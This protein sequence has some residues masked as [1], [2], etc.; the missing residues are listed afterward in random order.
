MPI[1]RLQPGADGSVTPMVDQPSE[2]GNGQDLFT[3]FVNSALSS[4]PETFG[5]SAGQQAQSFRRD[6]PWLGV[7]SEMAGTLVPYTGWFKAAKGIGYAAKAE[8]AADALTGGI[9][10]A[11]VIARAARAVATDAPFEVGR[12]LLSTQTGDNTG[13]VATSAATNLAL[14]GVLG[15]AIGAVKGVGRDIPSMPEVDKSVNLNDPLP[16]Q[17]RTL[18]ASKDAG[19]VTSPDAADFWINKYSDIVRR[20]EPYSIQDGAR[21]DAPYVNTLE[22]GGDSSRINR[23]FRT[24]GTQL[25][26]Q[27][28][29][30]EDFQSDGA[31]TDA[32]S[33][34]GLMGK[35]DYL[36]FP[37]IVTATGK[38]IGNAESSVTSALTQIAPDTWMRREANDGLYVMAKRVEQNTQLPNAAGGK[39]ALQ[40][41]WVLFKTDSPG[42]FAPLGDAWTKALGTAASW[43]PDT[44]VPIGTPINDALQ[45]ML[46]QFPLQN[47]NDTIAGGKLPTYVG[48]ARKALGVDSLSGSAKQAADSVYRFTK[49]HVAPAMFQ[50]SDSPRAAYIFNV[51][52][53]L[54]HYADAQTSKIMNGEVNP[55]D[56]LFH[57]VLNGPATTGKVTGAA[58]N[59]LDAINPL[60]DKLSEK[61]LGEVWLAR[62]QMWDPARVQSSII[63]GEISPQSG[64]AI[65]TLNALDAEHFGNV[66]KTQTGFDIP[67]SKPQIGH[68][69]I[70][71]TWRGS[72][73]APVTDA[74]GNLVIL[75]SG[76]NRAEA[77]AQADQLVKGGKAH[78]FNWTT[79]DTF[80]A[81]PTTELQQLLAGARQGKVDLGSRQ[82]QVANALR[83][84]DARMKMKPASMRELTG[85]K[86]YVGETQPWTKQELKDI[87]HA[88]VQGYQRYQARLNVENSMQGDLLK[89][90]NENPSMHQQIMRRLDDLAGRPSEFSQLQNRLL[91]KTPLGALLGKDSASKSV[92]ILNGLTHHLQLGL[93]NLSFPLVNAL[94]PLSTTLPQLAFV[95]KASAQDLQRAGY[96]SYNLV[97][98]ALGRP[99]TGAGF[100]NM[101]KLMGQSFQEMGKPSAE[102]TAHLGQAAREG[103]WSNTFNQE[104]IGPESAVGNKLKNA[105]AGKDGLAGMLTHWSNLLPNISERF[106]RVQSF[107]LGHIVGRDILGLK[108]DDLYRFAKRF[109]ENSNFAYGTADRARVITGPLGSFAGLYKNWQMHYMGWMLNYLDQGVKHDNWAPLIYQTLGTAA[110]GGIGGLAGFGAADGLSKMLTNK[111]LM[112]HVY[113]NFGPAGS[114][115]SNISDAVYFGLPAFLGTSLQSQAASP[116]A[117]P[118]RDAAMLFSLVQ[119]NRMKDLGT[120][121]GNG[122]DQWDATHENPM[123]SPLVRDNVLKV[124]APRSL[125][126]AIQS[127]D[128]GFIR[129][130]T[131]GNPTAKASVGERVLYAMGLNP[132]DVEKQMIISD[133]LWTD[134]TAMKNAVQAYAKAFDAAEGNPDDMRALMLRAMADGVPTDSIIRSSKSRQARE[135][136]SVIDRQFTP[137]KV[138]GY[139]DVLGK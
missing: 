64:T 78:G 107:S 6:N 104:V 74:D 5:F 39:P 123:H 87:L 9:K 10:A 137:L 84:A 37:R 121:L 24:D 15:G 102:L 79:Q 89:L 112:Q 56:S 88:H 25:K 22:D 125:A 96:Y 49:E 46:Q 109:T 138:K 27:R 2:A 139:E 20:E 119:Y 38:G 23:L 19:T 118:V 76:R 110:T 117:N 8:A 131:T 80:H 120:A 40:D 129:S 86:G 65:Q 33:Q 16:L 75:A 58:G 48:A 53:N 77:L 31:Y 26:A 54:Y 36:Q 30:P 59:A 51:A 95:L 97:G 90:M 41:K 111:D 132:V 130:L 106:S 72:I 93:G 29:V 124:L 47:Y 81:D 63:S 67:V 18:K 69:M 113:D 66:Q 17:L 14:A 105:L 28:L 114:D 44:N 116:G 122:M 71:N 57:Q 43:A 7:G 134:Q 108:D 21:V 11:P 4:I 101:A 98:D 91:D 34:S 103:Q 136:K 35:E 60:V 13:D 68:M 70:S 42:R 61:E 73:R 45:S 126:R 92:A 3:G 100:L 62:A 94:Q 128:D 32:L 115:T 133:K 1:I 99:R 85:V 55:N 83:V 135:Q 12:T 52:R 50:F 82:F 127:T